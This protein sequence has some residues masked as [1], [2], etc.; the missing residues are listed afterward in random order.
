MLIS[1]TS[2]DELQNQTQT[3]KVRIHG[4]E[5]PIKVNGNDE[6]YIQ[7][8]ANYVDEVMNQIS[9]QITVNSLTRLAILTALNI[10]DKL[11]V[12]Q[13]EKDRLET[14]VEEKARIILENLFKEMF[15]A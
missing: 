8:V 13:D 11:F 3:V 6:E 4:Q 10:T 2:M 14:S 7:R 9:D 1:H 15:D 12:A 5:Y